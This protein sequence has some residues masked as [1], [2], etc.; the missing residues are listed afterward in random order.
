MFHVAGSGGGR[1]G[2]SQ[3][4]GYRSTAETRV[5]DFANSHHKITASE[6]AVRA[7][8][9]GPYRLFVYREDG[10]LIGPA[11][12]I[13]A[14]NDAEAIAQAEA[15]RGSLSAELLDVEGLRIVKYLPANG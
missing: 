11:K 10:Q 4:L 15:I 8:S 13:H 9:H 12:I 14:A 3:H 2:H 5:L 7:R 1:V 6:T